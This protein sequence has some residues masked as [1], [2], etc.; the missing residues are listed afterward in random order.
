MKS[1]IKTQLIMKSDRLLLCN[2]CHIFI[3]KSN[4]TDFNFYNHIITFELLFK[5]KQCNL[6]LS[7]KNY[8]QPPSIVLDL[9]KFA[10]SIE[11]NLYYQPVWA[12]NLSPWTSCFISR[13]PDSTLFNSD[14][15]LNLLLCI[16]LV[17]WFA[18]N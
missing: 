9:E 2:N 7:K 16:W 3:S 6:I 15:N 12:G 17:M 11:K 4:W 8:P 14:F 1:F 13:L 10:P 18:Q 5:D